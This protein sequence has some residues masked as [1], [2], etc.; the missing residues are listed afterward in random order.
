MIHIFNLLLMMKTS[1]QMILKLIEQ[2]LLMKIR[3]IIQNKL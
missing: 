3:T 1:L 2:N